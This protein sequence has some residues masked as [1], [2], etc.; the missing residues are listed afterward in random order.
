MAITTIQKRS[1]LIWSR[2]R[3]SFESVASHS[4]KYR[5]DVDGLR[6]VAVLAVIFYH[7]GLR[8][9]RNGLVGVDVFYVISGYLITS[10]LLKDLEAGK[11]SII[12]FYERRM[13]RIFPALFTVLLFCTVCSAILLDPSEFE[14]FGKELLATTFFASNFYFWH[15]AQPLGYFDTGV[16][17]VPLLHTWSLSVEEQF[18]LFFPITL[19]LLFRYARKRIGVSS[20]LLSASSLALVSGQRSSSRW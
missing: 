10:L 19:F 20:L 3:V 17:S 4:A 6:A 14:K 1:A 5:P 13:R 15:S 7:L 16:I 8:N 2:A 9:F 18:Y 12:S 11:F